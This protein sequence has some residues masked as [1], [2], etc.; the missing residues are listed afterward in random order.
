MKSL[1]LLALIL[2]SAPALAQPP[3]GTV[4]ISDLDLATPAGVAKLDRRIEHAVA[5]LCG[6]ADPTDLNGRAQVDSCRAETMKS[7][8]DRRATLLARA[9][10]GS[11][12]IALKGR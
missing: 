1:T 5:Q 9:G 8:S 11:G 7:V 4:R 3:A 10:G 6:A 2:A 12:V